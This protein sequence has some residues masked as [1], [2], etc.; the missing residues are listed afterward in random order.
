M[1]PENIFSGLW[2]FE[3]PSGV[4]SALQV[5]SHSTPLDSSSWLPE[6]GRMTSKV[7]GSFPVS[8]SSCKCTVGLH[9]ADLHKPLVLW[10]WHYQGPPLFLHVFFSSLWTCSAVM[11]RF[12]GEWEERSI[13]ECDGEWEWKMQSKVWGEWVDGPLSN[14]LKWFSSFAFGKCPSGCSVQGRLQLAPLYIIL[15]FPSVVLF[16][17]FD[18]TPLAPFVLSSCSYYHLPPRSSFSHSVGLS[19]HW[20]PRVCC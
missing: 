13:R 17:L 11:D 5:C 4:M 3:I 16:T 14:L 7:T 19:V 9:T 12:G 10:S 8:S 1:C 20:W 18:F 6:P 15:Q 2:A